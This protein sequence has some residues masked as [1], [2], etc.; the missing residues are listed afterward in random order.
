[1]TAR[2]GSCGL[3]S[4]RLYASQSQPPAVRCVLVQQKRRGG[5][6]VVEANGLN[7]LPSCREGDMAEA[8]R[9]ESHVKRHVSLC[10]FRN[11]PVGSHHAALAWVRALAGPRPR[12]L[13]HL[14]YDP[15]PYAAH[16]I[17]RMA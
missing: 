2:F 10:T 13:Q 3:E 4:T 14:C 8:E 1:V 15:S 17:L 5:A 16:S 7:E 12:P 9:C 11:V 6:G